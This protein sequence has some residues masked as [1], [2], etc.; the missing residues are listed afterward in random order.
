VAGTLRRHLNLPDEDDLVATV[1]ARA[2][3]TTGLDARAGGRFARGRSV[4]PKKTMNT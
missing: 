2:A 4:D 1:T 3:H